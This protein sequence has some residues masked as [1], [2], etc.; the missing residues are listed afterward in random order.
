MS[1]SVESKPKRAPQ[2]K[3]IHKEL[4]QYQRPS[5]GH[6]IWQLV[7]T[8]IPFL[9]VFYAAIWAFDH[10]FWYA[11]PLTILSAGFMIRTFIIFHDCGHGSFFRSRKANDFWGM[12][13]GILT[14][15]P[16]YFWRASHAKHH[17][18]SANLDK[19]GYGDVWMMTVREYLE[20]SRKE[21]LK[22]RLYRNPFVMLVLG[23]LF[24]TLIT[25]RFVRGRAKN[26]KER[27]SVYI[28]NLGI[29][30]IA[31][32]MTYLVGFKSY[33]IVQ[34]LTLLFGLMTGIWLFYVQHQFEGVYWARDGE[35]DFTVASLEGGSFYDLPAVLRWFTG[36]IGYHH[37]HH[38][39]SSIPNYRLAK[40]HESIP[41]LQEISPVKLWPSFK[42]LGY[43][44]YDEERGEM[45]GFKDLKTQRM[46]RTAA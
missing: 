28:T 2:Q 14:F 23:P 31:S 21:R 38:L 35:W 3:R 5:R 20:A 17:A 7:N 26:D 10:S 22:Y 4:S 18:T 1:S 45:I 42:A 16:Y 36:S 8:I 15:T 44:L 13:T 24:I 25:H 37:V 6:S 33:I 46:A 43:R 29:L 34:T 12:V 11:L 41:D 40:C 30:V 27:W 32:A 19:R 9:G 39:N